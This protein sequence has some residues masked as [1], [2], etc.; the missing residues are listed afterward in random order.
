MNKAT[1]IEKMASDLGITKTAA[2]SAVES[3][4]AGITDA[5]RENQRVT[6]SG[7]GTWNVSERREREGRNPR[8]GEPIKINAKK[9]VRFKSGKQ[10]ESILNT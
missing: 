2:A 4:I 6:L 9:A 10:L 7:F 8:T 1:L 3:M 5:L